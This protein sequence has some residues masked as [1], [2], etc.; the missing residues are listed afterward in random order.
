MLIHIYG[1]NEVFTAVG[2]EINGFE[3]QIYN[4]WGEMIFE[5][6]DLY[7]G[8]DGS[9]KGNNTVSQEGVYVYNIQLTDGRGE[10]HK[11]LGHVTLI[12]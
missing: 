1:K 11:L 9:A 6:N 4:R 12:K 3:M 8:W 2:E 10:K 5:T 7:N